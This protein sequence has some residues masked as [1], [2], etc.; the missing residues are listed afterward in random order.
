MFWE[1]QEESLQE[2]GWQGLEAESLDF[3][4]TCEASRC[5]NATAST[6][7]RVRVALLIASDQSLAGKSL[8]CDFALC[9]LDLNGHKLSMT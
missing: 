9:L 8:A 5:G 7:K 2:S 3:H 4:P 1:I 6:R